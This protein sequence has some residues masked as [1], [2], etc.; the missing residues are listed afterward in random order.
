MLPGRDALDK[1]LVQR[2]QPL[3][4]A[5]VPI[6]HI[7]GD[8]DRVVPLAANSAALRRR[9]DES[10]AQLERLRLKVDEQAGVEGDQR[11]AEHGVDALFMR[12]RADVH[13]LRRHVG[14]AGSTMSGGQKQMLLLMRTYLEATHACT[15]GGAAPISPARNPPASPKKVRNI[16]SIE[17][18]ALAL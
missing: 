14:T 8:A 16:S 10:L 6:H 11:A 17:L 12:D 9:Y 4:A 3:A 7:H 13:Y 2:V 1:E 18:K 15:G 5:G